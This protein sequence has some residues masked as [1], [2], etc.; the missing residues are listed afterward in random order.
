M[1]ESDCQA[2]ELP[3]K[4]QHLKLVYARA[5]KDTYDPWCYAKLKPILE[6]VT[7][8]ASVMIKEFESIVRN[9]GLDINK[10]YKGAPRENND[11]AKELATKMKTITKAGNKI[12]QPNAKSTTSE[13]LYVKTNLKCTHPKCRK[14][15]KFVSHL[16]KECKRRPGGE[17]DDSKGYLNTKGNNNYRKDGTANK[18][19]ANY[20]RNRNGE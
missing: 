7:Q 13:A 18:F 5:V 11:Y 17:W 16:A 2:W 10:T 3:V 9:K 14:D 8:P 20:K 1:A 19:N 12:S 4:Q 6:N 15:R